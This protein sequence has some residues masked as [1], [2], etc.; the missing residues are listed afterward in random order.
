MEPRLATAADTLAEEGQ[1]IS[2]IVLLMIGGVVI[3]S[4]L[5]DLG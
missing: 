3:G 1:L 5:Q 2:A 4:A